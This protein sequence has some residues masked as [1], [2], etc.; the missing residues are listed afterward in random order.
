MN[1]F[2]IISHIDDDLECSDYDIT[3]QEQIYYIHLLNYLQNSNK[4]EIKRYSNIIKCKFCNYHILDTRYSYLSFSWSSMTM[5]YISH[6][7]LYLPYY[8]LNILDIYHH[9]LSLY[10][11]IR[12]HTF[13]CCIKRKKNRKIQMTDY[14]NGL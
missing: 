4:I 14:Y 12:L 6:H 5:H 11:K 10:K 1:D 9:S 3:K 7:Y 2:L 13:I 8:F